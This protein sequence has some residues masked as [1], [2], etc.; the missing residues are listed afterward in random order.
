VSPVIA[1]SLF[2]G[3]AT[4]TV[5][6]L[7]SEGGRSL[8]EGYFAQYVRSEPQT[9]IYRLF[10]ATKFFG[11]LAILLLFQ[12]ARTK[13]AY[14][15]ALAATL[16]L[17]FAHLL[18]G[19]RSM[20]FVYGLSLVVA[21][22]Y[23][24]HRIPL[25]ALAF[26][27]VAGSAV[28]FIVTQTRAAGIGLEI[29]DFRS[30]GIALN[31]LAILWEAG[32]VIKTV[33]RTMVFSANTG[34]EWGRTILD[35]ALA[36]IPTPLLS[37]FHISR[38]IMRPSVWLVENSSDVIPGAGLGY[39]LVAESYLNFGMFG[40]LL[41]LGIGWLLAVEYRKGALN[42]SSLRDILA[43]NMGVLFALHMRNDIDAYF[44]VLFWSYI[45]VVAVRRF[46]VFG[47][48]R[49]GLDQEIHEARAST[50]PSLHALQGE[51]APQRR[52]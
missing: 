46:S 16:A 9:P 45:I 32:S 43:L 22:D 49:F 5:F 19:S 6:Y 35:A 23:F 38:E 48:H 39:S 10:N 15:R 40:F 14:V 31:L 24:V 17:I 3:L 4:I 41:F 50:T 27:A 26:A 25:W 12:S 7:I 52:G 8:S 1:W 36:V 47:W 34:F 44:R 18:F 2:V 51:S 33:L 29:F 28:S 37:T 13:L 42:P 20:P 21:I 11:V 30:T